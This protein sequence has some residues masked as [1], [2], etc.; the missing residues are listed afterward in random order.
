MKSPTASDSVPKAVQDCHQLLLW[1][2]PLID[3]FP[4]VRRFTLGERLETNLL[5]VLQDLVEASY[6]RDKIAALN[7]ANLQLDMARHLWRLAFE[8][9]LCSLDRYEY[10]ARLLV[11]LG[12]QIGGWR[13]S[14]QQVPT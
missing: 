10:G 14:K 1:M 11:D 12:R 6:S 2:I 4:R 5:T 8:L 9:K 7:R 3:K 13:R